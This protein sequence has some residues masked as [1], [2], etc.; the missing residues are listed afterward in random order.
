MLFVRQSDCIMNGY[1]L[2]KQEIDIISKH[3]QA[4]PVNIKQ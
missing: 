2:C 3:I 4:E 1:I